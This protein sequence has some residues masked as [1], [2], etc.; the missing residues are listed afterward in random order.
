MSTPTLRPALLAAALAAACGLARAAPAADEPMLAYTVTAH[1]T[2]IGLNRTLF[3]SP[4]AWPEVAR[5]NKLPDP[6]RISPGQVLMVPTRLLHSKA[7]PATLA[8]AFGD[9]RIAGR[10]AQAGAALAPGEAI[11]TGDA[12]TAVVQLADGSRI[13]LVP[14][15]E[16][17]LDEH[18]RFQVRATRAAI[19][20]GLV[21]GTLRLVRGGIE[22]FATKVLRARPLEV[23]TPTA[24]I[25]V[26]GTVFRVHEEAAQAG[27]AAAEVLEG[28]VHVQ[29]G[30]APEQAVDV[31]VNYGAALVA[32]QAPVAEP[33]PA[34]PDLAALPAVVDRL[35]VRFK[36]AG[37]TPLHVQ[38]A[39]DAAFERI[40]F[41]FRVAAG[42]DIKLSGLADGRWNL[43]ARRIGA[44]G[45]EGLDGLHAF[46]LR[47][48]PEAPYLVEPP[49][50]A[51]RMVGDVPLRWTENPEAARYV[52]EVA[53]DAAFTQLALR[54]E[55]RGA[56]IVF[57]PVGTAYG[58]TD[59]LYFWRVESVKPDGAVGP[60]G[61]SQAFSLRP[62][63]RAPLGDMSPD[64]TAV[65]LMWGGRAED[66]VQVE[67]ARDPAFSEIVDRGAF[68]GPRGRLARPAPGAVY[69]RYRF[70][71][72]DGFETSW[73]DAVKITVDSSW[74]KALRALFGGGGK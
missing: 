30:G 12:S 6:N 43:R 69:A 51:K 40:A 65:E 58:A 67:L 11:T 62:V 23:S 17:R 22:V 15:S 26:R 14:D 31:P 9:V 71:E 41:D 35:P 70:I 61:E 46:E 28:K 50:G 72:P 66:R 60:V 19:D 59:G 42:D 1:D 21:A 27:A 54:E 47:A 34:A 32:G 4:K 48:H 68:T 18:R 3:A 25:G 8:S 73:S 64:G 49:N 20:D 44:Q 52:V 74:H 16:G 53:R 56:A 5:I 45:L 29:V 55:V 33:L 38:V 10:P 7:V 13:K 36:V 2:L 39:S 57:H 63:P 24:V 37:N